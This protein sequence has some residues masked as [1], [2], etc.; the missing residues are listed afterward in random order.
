MRKNWG[1]RKSVKF[2]YPV[3][4]P[5]NKSFTDAITLKSTVPPALHIISGASLFGNIT[6]A[7]EKS[8]LNIL[9]IN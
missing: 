3:Q 6:G 8:P 2:I 1:K 4:S 9:R 5:I 7:V